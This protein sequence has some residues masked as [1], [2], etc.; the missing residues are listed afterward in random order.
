M[1][2]RAGWR[3]SGG[4][5]G[6]RR[7]VPLRFTLLYMDDQN[8]MA[9]DP[10]PSPRSITREGSS[11]RCGPRRDSIED[12]DPSLTRKRQRLN[13][14]TDCSRSGSADRPIFSPAQTEP[15]HTQQTSQSR[16]HQTGVDRR[17]SS[18]TLDGSPSAT[19][20]GSP[21]PTS[22][23]IR[24]P[25]ANMRVDHPPL[26]RTSSKVTINVRGPRPEMINGV[27]HGSPVTDAER[28]GSSDEAESDAVVEPVKLDST[29]TVVIDTSSAVSPSTTSSVRSPEVEIAE[30]EDMEHDYGPPGWGSVVSVLEP[31]GDDLFMQSFPFYHKDCAM[32]D[33][34]NHIAR[35][36]EKGGSARLLCRL[37]RDLGAEF[38]MHRAHESRHG[39]RY[40][41]LARAL[42][43]S[44]RAAVVR[45]VRDLLRS[46]RVLERH[47]QH[48]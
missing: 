42:R 34:V 11:D 30:V 48:H 18:A 23:I 46:S 31:E 24:S 6:V 44:F 35:N 1:S 22:L 16:N 36:M 12:A 15:E 33:I 32:R 27:L 13:N 39:I 10:E 47:S 38:D 4:V 28:A 9:V 25:K 37:D 21:S 3:S 17:S 14:S 41:K 43:V 5:V 45:L 20:E 19:L 40:C 26:S 2:A 8:V 29:D 7:P